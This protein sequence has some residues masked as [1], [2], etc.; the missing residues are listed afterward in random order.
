MRFIKT[1][2][3]SS[4]SSFL[5]FSLLP[6]LQMVPGVCF[7]LKQAAYSVYYDA[8]TECS[9]QYER[10]MGLTEGVYHPGHCSTGEWLLK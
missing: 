4:L 6:C 1:P 8:L 7:S 3:L 5:C 2:N 9:R 10:E